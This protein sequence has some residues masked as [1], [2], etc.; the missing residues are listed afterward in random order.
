[1]IS[2]L[3]NGQ[4]MTTITISLSEDCFEQLNMLAEQAG[5]TPGELARAMF[6]MWLARPRA[7]FQDA[8]GYVLT[9][10]AELYRRLAGRSQSDS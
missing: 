7:K 8:A 4:F 9:K 10:N 5:V 6:E 1:M 2:R 3:P